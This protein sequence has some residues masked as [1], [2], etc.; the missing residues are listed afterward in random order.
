M[1]SSP[2]HSGGPIRNGLTV[3]SDLVYIHNDL[4]GV[5]GVNKE[6]GK[7]VWQVPSGRTMV[8]ETQ[9]RAFVFADAGLIKVMDNNT[10]RELYSVNFAEV[11]HTAQNTD[12]PVMFLGDA[13]G[14]LLSITVK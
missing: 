5:Y 9:S 12:S 3:G 14:R 2:F 4:S 1:W 10:G 13:T 6:T 7:A 8:C 11:S